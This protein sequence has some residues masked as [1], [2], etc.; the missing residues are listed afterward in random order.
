MGGWLAVLTVV[1]PPAWATHP[2]LP[3]GVKSGQATLRFLGLPIY[4]ARLWTPSPFEASRLGEQPLVLELEYLRSLR[5]SAIADRSIVEMRRAGTFTD[6][7]ARRWTADMQRVF[8]DVLPGDRLTGVHKPGVGA[9]FL[10]NDRPVG[11]IEDPQFARLFFSIWLGPETSEPTMRR[12][13]LARW[14][15]P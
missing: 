3:D 4:N 1:A 12:Q 7:Q 9:A 8:P 14:L 10:H 11:T 2:A 13:L 5:A 15:K 6:E